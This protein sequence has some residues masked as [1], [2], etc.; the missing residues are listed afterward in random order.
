MNPPKW[1]KD[2]LPTL[3]GWAHARTG[4]ILKVQKIPAHIVNA[5]NGI[6]DDVATIKIDTAAAINYRPEEVVFE[7]VSEEVLEEEVQ[8]TELS[9]EE[10]QQAPVRNKRKSSTWF[11]F[12]K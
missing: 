12:D 8:R 5:F 1:C 4:E 2:A 11:N 9:L 10:V 7:D 3:K 6:V